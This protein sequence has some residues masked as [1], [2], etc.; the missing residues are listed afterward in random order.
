MRIIYIDDFFHPD[1][2]YHINLLSKYW[3]LFGHEVFLLTAESEKIPES[4]K[5]FFDYSNIKEKDRDFE[6]KNRVKIIRLPII[7][8]IS[9]R[10]IYTKE[11]FRKIERI[12]PDIVYCNGNDSLIG[13]QLT[14][15]AKKAKY[16]LVLDSHMLEIA[17][18]N[19]FREAYHMFYKKIFAPIIIKQEIPVIRTQESDYIEKYLGIPLKM[20]P[21]ISFGSDT[22]N[23]HPDA[24]VRKR[25]RK[26]NGISQNA[27]VVVYAG[28]LNEA[29]GIDLLKKTITN[30]FNL[31]VEI[32]FLIVGTLDSSI[33]DPDKYFNNCQNR[34][35]RYPTQ[36]YPDLPKFYQASDIAIFPKQCSLSFYDVQACG[37]PVV[38]EDNSLNII[39]ASHG[40]ALVF[41]HDNVEDFRDKITLLANMDSVRFKT[42]QK[43]AIQYIM[44]NYDYKDKAMEYIPILES[45]L[46]HH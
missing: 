33:N 34:V 22:L 3:S 20:S 36:K 27:F 40:N 15:R 19:K 35:I 10:A 39:R 41:Q 6:L 7:R 8:V 5:S 12:N 13:M 29:K 25:F 14:L 46:K 31:G 42:M 11:I 28:K 16:G 30:K 1:A 37:L 38:F 24:E 18:V 17:S 21:F 44:E 9:G 2:G 43:H 45:K 23:F 4:L 26:E 32:V